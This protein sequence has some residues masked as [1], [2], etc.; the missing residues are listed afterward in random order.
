MKAIEDYQEQ[1]RIEIWRTRTESNS[2]PGVFYTTAK[3]SDGTYECDCPGRRIHQ[4]CHHVRGAILLTEGIV[5]NISPDDYDH[6]ENPNRCETC[7]A[8]TVEYKFH[9][10]A[11]LKRALVQLYKAGTGEVHRTDMK[12]IN[13][14]FGNFTKLKFFGLVEPVYNKDGTRKGGTWRITQLGIDF[15]MGKVPVNKYVWTYRNSFLRFDGP[16]I[17]VHQ[18]GGKYP[19]KEQYI[20]E[21]VPHDG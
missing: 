3:Y 8:N 10:G 20:K 17:Y 13:N 14:D 1:K 15:L 18:V 9:L 6:G 2:N 4:I 19:E 21:S 5:C 16:L 12:H 11:G 7:G